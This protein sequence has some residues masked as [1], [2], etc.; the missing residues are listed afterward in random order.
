[1]V[2]IAVLFLRHL[3]CFHDNNDDGND[4]EEK[5]RVEKERRKGIR[6]SRRQMTEVKTMTTNG[7]V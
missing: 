3:L 7:L 5:R 4:D 6:K 1:M 2:L